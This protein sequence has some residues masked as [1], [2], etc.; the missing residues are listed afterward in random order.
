M[1]ITIGSRG[2][3]DGVSA[4]L[5]REEEKSAPELV[6]RNSVLTN[7]RDE[8]GPQQIVMRNSDA[9]KSVVINS[10]HLSPGLR[11]YRGLIPHAFCPHAEKTKSL[12][13]RT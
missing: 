3:S 6:I 7:G 2:G 10:S 13:A 8:K 5:T 4:V 9:G 1:C 11:T 12:G